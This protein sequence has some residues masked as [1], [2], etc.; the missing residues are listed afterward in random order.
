MVR[1]EAIGGS[2]VGVTSVHGGCLLVWEVC[3][4]SYTKICDREGTPAGPPP[5]SREQPATKTKQKVTHWSQDQEEVCWFYYSKE[6]EFIN[7]FNFFSSFYQI[8]INGLIRYVVILLIQISFNCDCVA[9]RG[10]RRRIELCWAV[11]MK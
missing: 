5:S 8:E 11:D 2:M 4:R 1:C 6:S 3:E 9:D 7:W 10:I